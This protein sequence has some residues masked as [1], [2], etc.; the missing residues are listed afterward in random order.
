LNIVVCE[1]IES[2][3]KLEKQTALQPV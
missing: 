1:V 3:K 2:I